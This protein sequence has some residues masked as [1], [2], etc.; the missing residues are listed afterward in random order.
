MVGVA[1]LNSG[2]TTRGKAAPQAANG[3]VGISKSPGT[4]ALT[5]D[6]SVSLLFVWKPVS[7]TRRKRSK[8]EKMRRKSSSSDSSDSSSSS[9]KKKKKMGSKKEKK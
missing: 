4:T 6:K 9:D 3:A 8:K 5:V 1:D 7:R 2:A